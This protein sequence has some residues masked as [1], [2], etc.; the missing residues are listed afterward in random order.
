MWQQ[1]Y[2]YHIVNESRRQQDISSDDEARG[3]CTVGGEK[4]CTKILQR[5][6]LHSK[7]KGEIQRKV[8]MRVSSDIGLQAMGL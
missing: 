3:A 4:Q 6:T 5:P 7:L 8:L 2:K 1:S